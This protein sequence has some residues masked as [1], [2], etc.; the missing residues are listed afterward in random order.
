LTEAFDVQAEPAEDIEGFRAALPKKRPW[1]TGHM[2]IAAVA[3]YAS[4]VP[5]IRFAP[6]VLN[7][8]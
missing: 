1:T 7:P 4:A 8:R 2:Q 6:P 5:G 3:W